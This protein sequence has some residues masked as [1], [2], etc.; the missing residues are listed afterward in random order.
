MS[1]VIVTKEQVATFVARCQVL[2][3]V[4]Y[5][6]TFS[7]RTTGVLKFDYNVN[8]TYCRIV[9]VEYY[10]DGI[11]HDNDGAA[12]CFINLTNGDVL[13]PASW[14]DPIKHTAHGNIFDEHQ[15]ML[16]MSAFG[17]GYLK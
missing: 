8:N 14:A 13:K 9:N 3:D 15:G 2:M 16:H 1:N 12:W 6:N 10:K 7:N 5:T 11:N 17:P 4:F